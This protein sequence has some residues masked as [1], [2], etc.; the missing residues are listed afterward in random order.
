MKTKAAGEQQAVKP[1]GLE[2]GMSMHESEGTHRHKHGGLCGSHKFTS[3]T[4]RPANT[5]LLRNANVGKK[6]KTK[7]NKN[8]FFQDTY[9]LKELLNPTEQTHPAVPL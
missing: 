8:Q 9:Y 3:R 2:A 4:H 7:Q 1:F 6:N 5:S